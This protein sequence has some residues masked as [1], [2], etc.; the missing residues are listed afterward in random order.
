MMTGLLISAATKCDLRNLVAA[1]LSL[2]L[3][4][5]CSAAHAA[6]QSTNQNFPTPL[7]SNEIS[8][9]IKARDAGDARLTTYYFVFDADQ[10]D[11]FLN[12]VT[13]NL[14]GDIDVFTA[15]NLRPMTKVTV[16]S[17]NPDGET[18]RVI[19]VRQPVRLLLRI[20]GKTPTD[21][22]ATY[23]IKF[24]GSFKP[25]S[26][27]AVAE[28]SDPV[29]KPRTGDSDV[30]V[31]SVGTIVEVRPKPTPTP[32]AVVTKPDKVPARVPIAGRDDEEKPESEKSKTVSPD[33]TSVARNEK[34]VVV[35]TEPEIPSNSNSEEK[36]KTER[37]RKPSTQPKKP[38]PKK[39]ADKKPAEEK[40]P[41]NSSDKSDAD[42]ANQQKP[43]VRTPP[44]PLN[45]AV[46]AGI[47]LVILFKDGKKIEKQMSE[48][49]RF[50]VDRGVLTVVARDGEIGRYSM[51]D[52][53]K[54]TIE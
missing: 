51:L 1:F 17:D 49:I 36:P 3:I 6:A 32:R 44:K 33:E 22:P 16:F 25:L 37:P 18:G 27:S 43:D 21:D 38:S 8:G 9:V 42:S 35:V 15:D 24:A 31:N 41:A 19:Y 13:K 5:V 7:T 26:A 34:P 45:P 54:V 46:L 20:E 23:R 29:V 10:G 12:I 14:D 40:T 4:F 2:A 39:P 52:V 50:G 11:V 47:K 53:E 30:K 28:V 48:I